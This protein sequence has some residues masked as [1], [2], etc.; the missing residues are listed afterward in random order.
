MKL[1]A[2]CLLLGGL[3][4][5]TM[6]GTWNLDN[7]HSAIRFKV[8]HLMISNVG[9]EFKDYKVTFTTDENDKPTSI[10]AAIEAKSINTSNEKR[11]E[12]LRNA[13]FFEV[14][15][16][17]QITFKSKK[18]TGNKKGSYKITGDLTLR[19]ITKEVTLDGTLSQAIKDPFG[20]NRR[21]LSAKTKINRKDFA[22]AWN[23]TM[24]SG[25]VVVSDA[26]DIDVEL[27]LTEAKAQ[28]KNG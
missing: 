16:H 23:K 20:L 6:A 9:G 5:P 24:D 17:P 26:V 22:M 11:D 3:A 8:R 4:S 14:E 18:I 28:E 2:T 19:G 21:A 1:L 12:H 7:S 13:D 10:E 27:E 25:G 15:K